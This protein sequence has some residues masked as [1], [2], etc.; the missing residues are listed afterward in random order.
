MIDQVVK[1]KKIFTE[2]EGDSWFDRN[3]TINMEERISEDLIL[4]ELGRLNFSGAS[5]LEIGCADGWRLAEIRSRYNWQCFGIDPSNKAIM[6]GARQYDNISLV[7][8]TA[9]S[10]PYDD[11]SMSVVVIGFCLYLCDRDELFKISS[12]IDRVLIDGGLIL[13]L[14]FY[15]EIPYRNSYSHLEGIYSYKM[16]YSKLFLWNPA[17]QLVSKFVSSHGFE[18]VVKDK[19]ERIM[20]SSIRKSL[21]DAYSETPNYNYE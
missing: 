20:I 17:Y 16:D 2:G 7:Q 14:D 15:S 11:Q 4:R 18:T 21:L 10:L 13:I 3:S 1:Q 19:D 8:G 12:E 5:C 9:D 6:K